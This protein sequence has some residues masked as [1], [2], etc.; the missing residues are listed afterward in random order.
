LLPAASKA[1]DDEHEHDRAQATTIT[2]EINIPL[3]ETSFGIGYGNSGPQEGAGSHTET[4]A[5]AYS[6]QV[7]PIGIYATDG[8]YT[9]KFS[10]KSFFFSYPGYFEVVITMGPQTCTVTGCAP[11]PCPITG[12]TPANPGSQEICSRDG[13]SES[14]YADVTISCPNPIYLV[15]DQSLS[16][17]GV[18]PATQ[19]SMLPITLTFFTP[20]WS[21]W[22]KDASFTFTPKDRGTCVPFPNVYGACQP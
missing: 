11:V 16:L 3:T 8:V 12:C 6:L 7:R 19:T 17:P 22:Y 21:V 4:V 20:S 15:I 10:V 18:P 9:L 14:D 1:Q 2:N 13:W 5:S